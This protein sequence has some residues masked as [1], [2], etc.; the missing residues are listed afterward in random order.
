MTVAEVNPTLKTVRPI[1]FL[2]HRAET[3]ID[4]LSSFT[5]VAKDL[6]REAVDCNL[7]VTGPIHWHYFGFTGEG[8]RPFVLEVALPVAHAV[9]DYDGSFHFKRTEPFACVSLVHEGRW[10]DLPF[11]YEKLMKFISEKGLTPSTMNREIYVNTDFE[12]PEANVTEIQ[13]GIN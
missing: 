6:Y 13:I 10:S 2:F 8:S 11:S 4:D 1:T 7:Q 12:D 9:P 3:F 5:A